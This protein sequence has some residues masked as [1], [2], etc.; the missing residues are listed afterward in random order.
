MRKMLSKNSQELIKNKY[1]WDM[2]VKN[3]LTN[4]D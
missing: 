2:R 4:I 1:S 3:M